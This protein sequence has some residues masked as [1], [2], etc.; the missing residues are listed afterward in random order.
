MLVSPPAPPAYGL[1]RFAAAPSTKHA[2]ESC[3]RILP[4]HAALPNAP[5]SSA[6]A[7]CSKTSQLRGGDSKRRCVAPCP[8][9]PVPFILI[10]SRSPKLF[11]K[12][13]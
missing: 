4:G 8:A 13:W 6:Q 11:F 2:E 5:S 9:L 10:R 12:R 1:H 3:G 7:I